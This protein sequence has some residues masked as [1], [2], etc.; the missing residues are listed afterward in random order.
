MADHFLCNKC[1]MT[2]PIRRR[3][4]IA[5]EKTRCAI[6]GCDVLFWHNQGKRGAGALAIVGIDPEDAAALKTTGGIAT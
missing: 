1:R 2:F 5:S 6:K 4:S 3:L